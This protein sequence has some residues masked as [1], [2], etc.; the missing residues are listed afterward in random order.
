MMLRLLACIGSLLSSLALIRF[1]AVSL[2]YATSSTESAWTIS[3]SG[4]SSFE[5]GTSQTSGGSARTQQV[6]ILN[7]KEQIP[8][9]WPSPY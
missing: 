1:V 9:G 3:A 7:L 5:L 8:S 6:V 4:V 2:R